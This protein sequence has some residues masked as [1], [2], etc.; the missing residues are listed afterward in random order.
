[1]PRLPPRAKKHVD[2]KQYAP[3]ACRPNP[4]AEEKTD[5]DQG[6]QDA[7]K[8]SKENGVWLNDTCQEWAIQTD[9]TVGNVVLQIGLEATMRESGPRE[10]IFSEQ[11]EEYR[12]GDT[13]D[14][15]RS[16]QLR[17]RRN[18][19]RGQV[20][21]ELASG[22]VIRHVLVEGIQFVAEVVHAPF[23]EIADR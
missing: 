9:S 13:Q 7:N 21:I 14:C 20:G 6:F 17:G 18:L 12:R 16:E 19:F 3:D 10:F 15:D 23:K 11:K 8:V 1:V 2:Q 4:E 22:T 5:S